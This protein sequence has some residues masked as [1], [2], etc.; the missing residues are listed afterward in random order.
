MP[1]GRGAVSA[2]EF[3]PFP[4]PR[5]LPLAGDRLACSRLALLW[6][7]SVL[8]LFCEQA[9]SVWPEGQLIFPLS[10]AIPQFKLLSHV[11]FL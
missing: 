9:H 10:L 4:S 7:C 5:L 11:S 6:D 1:F 3:A 2:A 8:P